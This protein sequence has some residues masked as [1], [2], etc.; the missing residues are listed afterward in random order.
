VIFRRSSGRDAL[1]RWLRHHASVRDRFVALEEALLSGRFPTYA[2]RRLA[3]FALSR[4]WAIALH[5]VELT[6]LVEVF[7][8][9]A[10]VAGV[11]LQNVTL[12]VDA[13]YW[14]A[15]ESLRRRL[16]ELGPGSASSALTSRWMTLSFGIAFCAVAMPAL[17]AF[18][19]ADDPDAPPMLHAY[20]IACGLRL[21]ADVVLR[22]YYSGI[23]AFRRVHRTVLAVLAGPTFFVG[24]VLLAWDVLGGWSFVVAM[25]VSLAVSRGL[26]WLYTRRAYRR[27]R[28]PLPT[29]RMRLRGRP[30]LATTKE[31]FLA[32]AANLTSRLGAI[33]LLAAVIPSLVQEGDLAFVAPETAA[34]AFALH[35]AAP[36]LFLASQWSFVFYHD[37]KRLD[38][39]EATILAR[40]FHRRLLGVGLVV[41]LVGWAGTA[42]LTLLY[43]PW[44]VVDETLLALLGAVV[45]LS[46]WTATQ[47]RGFARGDFVRQ[48]TSA[49]VLAGVVWGALS[50]TLVGPVSWYLALAA[51][52]WGAIVLD[53]V[54]ERLRRPRVTG[55]APT[56]ADWSRALASAR[57]S[58]GTPAATWR[59]TTAARPD[60]VVSRVA[61]ALGASG[62][63]VR[64]GGIVLWFEAPAV[65]SRSEWLRT[66]GGALTALAHETTAPTQPAD[67]HRLTEL[68]DR[69]AELFPDGFV[70]ALGRRPPARF[71]LLEPAERQA[72]W[73][74]ALRALRG[75]RGRSRHFVTCHC[76]DGPVE[77]VFATPRPVDG[78]RAEKWRAILAR[79]AYRLGPGF[80]NVGL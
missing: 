57:R 10:F 48:L 61:S 66:C 54:V 36:F 29:W 28:V 46:L 25:V 41:G 2:G 27:H 20:A 45:G 9:K 68:R 65:R 42:L 3:A 44:G 59:A 11:A 26:L 72:I 77:A 50:S 14:G 13:F 33:V 5:V 80:G 12:V 22:T 47:L 38:R 78:L 17:F 71:A 60:V 4:A 23:F 62:A 64:V 40:H 18:A 39:A 31:A 69:Y 32:G 67:A 79:A 24:I 7:S 21:A 58:G 43:L 1:E 56:L 53:A 49:A 73:E 74:D 6:F 19:R 8:S 51:G 52:P 70:V 35:L 76:P 34:F 55:E 75:A 63:V 15:L 30:S 16:R 37:W